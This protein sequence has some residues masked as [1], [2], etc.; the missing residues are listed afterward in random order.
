VPAPRLADYPC[1]FDEVLAWEASS[2]LRNTRPFNAFGIPTVTVPCGRTDED[3][4][5]GLQLAAAPWQ[6][7]RALAVALAYESATEWHG[8]HPAPV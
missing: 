3:L 1:T 4:P 6:E 5:I 7:R 2:I 8:R